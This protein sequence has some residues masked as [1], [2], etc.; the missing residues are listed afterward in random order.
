MSKGKIIKKENNKSKME[1]IESYSDNDIINLLNSIND[2]GHLKALKIMLDLYV[3]MNLRSN[4]NNQVKYGIQTK[5]A[6]VDGLKGCPKDVVKNKVEAFKEETGKRYAVIYRLYLEELFDGIEDLDNFSVEDILG[7]DAIDIFIEI[8]NNRHCPKEYIENWYKYNPYIAINED[9]EEKIKNLTYTLADIEESKKIQEIENIKNENINLN[10]KIN[11]LE[12]ML[13]KK[14]EELK[15]YFDYEEI[16][17]QLNKKKEEC[18]KLEKDNEDKDDKLTEYVSANLDLEIKCEQK[19]TKIKD[20]E[21]ENRDLKYTNKQ[22]ERDYKNLLEKYEVVSNKKSFSGDAEKMKKNLEQQLNEK[23]V[24][25]DEL[26]KE[27]D[28]LRE[29]NEDIIRLKD[30]NKK[31]KGRETGII[32]DLKSLILSDKDFQKKFKRIILENKPICEFIVRNIPDLKEGI[33]QEVASRR[34]QREFD[35]ERK[36]YVTDYN[37]NTITNK[38]MINY[39]DL[40]KKYNKFCTENGINPIHNLWKRI[41]EETFFIFEDDSIVKLLKNGNYNINIERVSVKPNWY[42]INDWFG[43]FSDGEFKPSKTD[44]SDFYLNAKENPDELGILVL[45][46][47]NL[48]PPEVYIEPFIKDIDCNGYVNLVSPET[49]IVEG[50]EFMTIEQL[51]NLKY[52][53]IKRNNADSSFMIPTDLQKYELKGDTNGTGL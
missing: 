40:E 53:F 23:Q 20:L 14:E 12:K 39:T 34:E 48:I 26:E 38:T 43:E 47:F 15:S 10:K 21:N 25:I 16:K 9:I 32:R 3:P 4:R 18:Q 50:Y 31:L 42:G 35:R 11:E 5:Q 33:E 24:K 29:S 46:N 17:E 13:T 44:I 51:D 41:Q 36:K 30:E 7:E 22:S 6:F 52:F 8:N 37:V 49:V 45:D 27:N 2:S 1:V 28:E 19:D